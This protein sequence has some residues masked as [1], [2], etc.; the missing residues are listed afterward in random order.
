MY[1]QLRWA[2]PPSCLWK[3]NLLHFLLVPPIDTLWSVFQV[4]NQHFQNQQVQSNKDM[5]PRFSKKGQLNLDE[6]QESTT[7]LATFLVRGKT[8]L[9][10]EHKLNTAVLPDWE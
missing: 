5:P 3:G 10:I 2:V 4:Q 9:T 1:T 7:S 8:P 6:V